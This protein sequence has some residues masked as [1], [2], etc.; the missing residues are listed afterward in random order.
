M[1]TGTQRDKKQ[2]DGHGDT[3]MGETSQS[4]APNTPRCS[5][6]PIHREECTPVHGGSSHRTFTRRIV[7]YLPVSCLPAL[8]RSLVIKECFLASGRVRNGGRAREGVGGTQGLKLRQE[9]QDPGKCTAGNTSSRGSGGIVVAVPY[10]PARNGR[11]EGL[12]TLRRSRVWPYLAP[13]NSDLAMS[14]GC[15]L[16]FIEMLWMAR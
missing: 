5:T 12:S 1:K 8:S 3:E 11:A 7:P 6:P 13:A 9:C 2:K 4:M 15:V 10:S 16:C 14:A